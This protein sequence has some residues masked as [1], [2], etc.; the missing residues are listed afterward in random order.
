L[1][2]LLSKPWLFL[3]LL[4]ITA[5]FGA[6]LHAQE[7]SLEESDH[8]AHAWTLVSQS[9]TGFDS[10]SDSGDS[11]GSF[12]FT[13]ATSTTI[14]SVALG[15]NC[16]SSCLPAPRTELQPRTSQGPPGLTV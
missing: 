4:V 16:H 8:K 15:I 9:G 1:S 10:S 13:V 14:S 12:S 6:F 2:A 5:D 3:Y 11:D 7:T